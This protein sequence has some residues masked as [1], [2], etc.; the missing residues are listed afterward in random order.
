MAI[1]ILKIVVQLSNLNSLSG[2]FDTRFTWF[3]EKRRSRDANVN[4]V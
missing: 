1:A 4:F 3:P 2:F